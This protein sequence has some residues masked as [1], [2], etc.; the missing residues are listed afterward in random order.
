MTN[1]TPPSFTLL[2]PKKKAGRV[3]QPNQKKEKAWA[4]LWKM[5]NMEAS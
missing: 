5:M 1:D 4:K 2:T 3:F